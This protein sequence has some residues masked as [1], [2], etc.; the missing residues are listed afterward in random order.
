MFFVH[1]ANFSPVDRDEIQKTKPKWW[2]INSYRSRLLYG[3]V[4]SCNFTATNGV[5]KH[6]RQK[7]CHLCRYVAIA[8]LFK[9]RFVPVTRSVYRFH[10]GCRDLGRKV[11]DLPNRASPAS[12]TNQIET[13]RRKEW[14]GREISVTEP[15]L[16]TGLIWRDQSENSKSREDTIK[17]SLE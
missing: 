13:L 11:R 5:E 7:L 14:R 17:T 15:A 2:N 10:P 6:T 9:R 16:L 8:K 4:D 3:F 12:H 1:M